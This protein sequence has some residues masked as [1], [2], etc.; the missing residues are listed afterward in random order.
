MM[1]SRGDD[2][3]VVPHC[4]RDATRRTL[5]DNKSSRSGLGNAPLRCTTVDLAA[6]SPAESWCLV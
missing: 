4:V 6:L 5:E 1:G 3:G 2:P